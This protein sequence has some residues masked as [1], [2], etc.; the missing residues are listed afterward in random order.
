MENDG[1]GVRDLAKGN[2]KETLWERDG[3][4]RR[5]GFCSDGSQVGRKGKG[6]MELQPYRMGISGSLLEA[7][8]NLS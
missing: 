7:R 6:S 5:M 8:P 1:I 4:E 3:S 2:G